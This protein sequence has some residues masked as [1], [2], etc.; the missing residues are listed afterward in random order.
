VYITLY[1]PCLGYS[2]LIILLQPIFFKPR[3]LP[4]AFSP[5]PR[6]RFISLFSRMT[7]PSHLNNLYRIDNRI[8][9]PQRLS[10]PKVL[11][12]PRHKPVPTVKPPLRRYGV[13]TPRVNL[14]V[15]L[16]V[17]FALPCLSFSRVWNLPLRNTSHPRVRCAYQATL[18]SHG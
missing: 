4:P 10:S 11:H 14:S 18:V 13:E 1:P 8:K 5:P 17:S 6:H 16:V 2:S 3:P 9:L 15:T 7:V 12:P